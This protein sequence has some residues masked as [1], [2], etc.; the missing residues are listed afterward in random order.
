MNEDSGTRMMPVGSLSLDKQNARAHGPANLEAIKLSLTRFGQ[1]KPIIVSEEGVVYAGNGTLVAARE[2]G[3]ETIKVSVSALPIEELRAY[4]LADNRSAELAEWDTE[5]LALSLE[6]LADEGGGIDAAV[7]LGW[8]P[9]E[10]DAI[11]GRGL[12][13]VDLSPDG[14]GY[15]DDDDDPVHQAIPEAMNAE[16]EEEERRVREGA[17]SI[18]F[19]DE[20]MSVID[21]VALR[22]SPDEEM[23]RKDA[24]MNRIYSALPKGESALG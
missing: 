8:A 22:L 21:A 13:D 7:E 23:T 20:E 11:L 5:A 16:L 19:T 14:E 3:W 17:T 24:I 4:A 10:V 18:T 9:H 12:D 1:Q 2:L 15:D 6:H